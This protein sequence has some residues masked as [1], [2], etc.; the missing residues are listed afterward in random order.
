MNTAVLWDIEN[1]S[2]QANKNLVQTVLDKIRS[3]GRICCAMAFGDWS[4][5]SIKT[6]A[7]ELHVHNFKLIHIPNSG[8]N[9][10]DLALTA[11]G[12][13]ALF[14]YPH[15]ERY[16]LISG[17]ADFRDLLMFLKE[18]GKEIWIICN[19]QTA[20]KDFLKIADKSID[21]GNIVYGSGAKEER[22]ERE[23]KPPQALAEAEQDSSDKYASDNYDDTDDD[24]EPSAS[25]ED[26]SEDGVSPAALTK[27]QA[28]YQLKEAIAEINAEG[29]EAYPTEVKAK[30]PIYSDV[31]ALGYKNWYD[32]VK[33]AEKYGLLYKKG[34]F[35]IHETVY[36]SE[37]NRPTGMAKNFYDALKE[38]L[39]A[40]GD[41]TLLLSQLG[42][43]NTKVDYKKYNYARLIDLVADAEE[44]GYVTVYKS[45]KSATVVKRKENNF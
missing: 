40:L 37:P 20:S 5:N 4:N 15:L 41:D 13:E 21:Y 16:V 29:K 31:K 25:E 36:E 32:F 10:A 43:K 42:E 39:K 6:I 44:H 2:P 33:E 27:K 17:D 8:K 45:S 28:I 18:Y 11:H 3:A 23:E 24:D 22:E 19:M 9:S 1:V 26:A 30:A 14:K 7:A 35:S 38:L 34:V 12:M